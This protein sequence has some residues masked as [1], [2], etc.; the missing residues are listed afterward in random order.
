MRIDAQSR[1]NAAIRVLEIIVA[2]ACG[3]RHE[4]VGFRRKAH[5]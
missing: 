5:T 1:E 4:D 3:I 2:A